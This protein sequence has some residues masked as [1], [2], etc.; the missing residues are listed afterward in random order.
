MSGVLLLASKPPQTPGVLSFGLVFELA[1]VKI[2]AFPA[3]KA[4]IL[5]VPA[6]LKTLNKKTTTTT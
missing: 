3:E 6:S 2:C 1:G 4:L 5:T